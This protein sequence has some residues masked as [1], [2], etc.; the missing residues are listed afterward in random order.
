[1]ESRGGSVKAP[2][3]RRVFPSRDLEPKVL[4]AL[5]L[6]AA[7]VSGGDVL[8]DT[9]TADAAFDAGDN[10]RALALYDEVLAGDPRDMHALVRSGMLLAWDRRFDEALA[11]YDRAL[12]LDPR[13]PKARLE[14][15]KV[16]LWSRRFDEAREAFGRILAE[17][18]ADHEALLA[19]ARAYAWDGRPAE[20]RQHY[21]RVLDREP[22]D[23]E[24][25]VGVAQ[26]WAWSGEGSR[27]RPY[28]ERA[29]AAKPGM[30]EA[31]MGLA[32]LDLETGDTS[33]AAMRARA[34]AEAYPKDAEV[35]DLVAAVDKA[36]A[37]WI[38]VGY[39]HL[40][41]TDDNAYDT[42]RLEGGFGL[43]ARLDLRF[44]VSGTELDG[45]GAAVADD[46]SAVTLYGVLG[47]TPRPR[48]RGELRVGAAR[49]TRG[50]GDERTTAIG[51][52]TYSFPLGAWTARAAATHDPFVYSPAILEAEV[53][54][55]SLSFGAS[56]RAARRVQVEAWGAYGD[57]SD[58]N[59]RLNGEAA[60]WYV[61]KG[62]RT[63]TLA[64]GLIR[65]QRF[66]DDLDHGYFDP[67]RLIAPVGS[68]RS[69]GSI[70]GSVWTYDGT[71]EAGVQ[72]YE[73]NGEESSS[74]GLVNVY[75]LVG[76]PLP[77]GIGL[78]IYAGWSNS[79]VTAGPNFRSL[80]FGARFRFTIGG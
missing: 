29:L 77:R 16:F 13:E 38:S 78:E 40:G 3:G 22:E 52:A 62:S 19:M 11:R 34:L 12:A 32:Y 41:D 67:Q 8:A 56:G 57:F 20:A 58:G 61:W 55:T 80:S 70:G 64:G 68:F 45:P 65:G 28:F 72:S 24:A 35:R 51:G 25:L 39:D 73:F 50:G 10:P 5:L 53:D 9:A 36:R 49:L 79:S 48:H 14:R 69:Y 1:M 37:P 54:I 7:F 26:T 44:G 47:W 4:V 74:Q 30:K 46:G 2:K 15:G 60:A 76:R 43:P 23:P 66:S 42:L 6:V 59:V 63:T 71:F 33:S 27:A 75:G 21:Q 31:Q 17:D 18:P